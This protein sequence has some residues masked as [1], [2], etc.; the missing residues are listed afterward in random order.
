MLNFGSIL[1]LQ[2]DNAI[3]VNLIR[4]DG[5]YSRKNGFCSSYLAGNHFIIETSMFQ[6][7]LYGKYKKSGKIYIFK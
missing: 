3:N 5:K 1:L 6:Y 2:A 4:V 7:L